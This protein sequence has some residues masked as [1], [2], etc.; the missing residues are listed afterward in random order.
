MNLNYKFI[1]FNRHDYY[2]GP[3]R[4]WPL[5]T[6]TTVGGLPGGIS[7]S[8]DE[9]ALYNNEVMSGSIVAGEIK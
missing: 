6:I 4:L 9:Y 7:G 8:A 5:V 1:K 3:S 2:L